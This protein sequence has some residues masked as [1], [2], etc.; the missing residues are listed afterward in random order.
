[1]QKEQEEVKPAVALYKKVKALAPEA[2]LWSVDCAAQTDLLGAIMPNVTV[3]AYIAGPK[4]YEGSTDVARGYAVTECEALREFE[5]ELAKYR[6]S[7]CG[8]DNTDAA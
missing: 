1:M 4:G 6:K 8:S 3:R 5:S 7:I 2:N